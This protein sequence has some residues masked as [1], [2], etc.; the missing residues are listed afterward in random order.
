[1]Q[2][3]KK[4]I[5]SN[6]I[7]YDSLWV[8]YTLSYH[9]FRCLVPLCLMSSIS[10]LLCICDPY[11][12]QN[13]DIIPL[14]FFYNSVMYFPLYGCYN[15]SPPLIVSSLCSLTSK[16]DLSPPFWH[17]CQRILKF[18]AILGQK[19][20]IDLKENLES[21]IPVVKCNIQWSVLD[22]KLYC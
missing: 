20:F 15:I 14:I 6:N 3:I 17:W 5:V 1:M 16:I 9:E 7:P 12:D 22:C 10:D 21:C 11:A 8:D 18:N 13:F 2:K 4:N 19:C